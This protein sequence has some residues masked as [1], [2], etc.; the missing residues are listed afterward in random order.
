[1]H[2]HEHAH[3]EG[4]GHDEHRH[5][6]RFRHGR[7]GHHGFGPPFRE[8]RDFPSRE[9]LLAKLER[10]QRDLEERTADVVD[11]IRRLKTEEPASSDPSA[12]ATTV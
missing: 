8:G 7:H 9:A 3:A 1:M 4:R 12:P 10:Y 11:M 5:G 2:E 6:R